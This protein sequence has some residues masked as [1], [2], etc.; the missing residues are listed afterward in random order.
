MSNA[1]K[2]RYDFAYFFEITD[3]NPNGDP[4]AGNLP[5]LDAETGQGLVTDV[6]LKRK[7]RNHVDL[8]K[9][10]ASSYRIFVREKAILN[11]QIEEAYEQ[12]DAVRAALAEWAAYQ[13]AKK[14]KKEKEGK[15]TERQAPAP[16]HF[17][18][19]A[20]MWMCE[21]FFDIRTFGAVMTTGKEKSDGETE[22][23][24]RRTAG[25]VR[26]P[27]QLGI[28]RSLHPIVS[29][30]HAL[31]V[32]AARTADKPIAEQVGIQGRKFTIPYALYR[33]HGFISP[34]LAGG[35][36]GT[37]F[38]EDDLALL[39]T[40]LN[41]MFENDKSAARANMRP[42]ACIAFRHESPL[43]NARADQLFARVVC[44]PAEGVQ[45]LPGEAPAN[46]TT[47]SLRPPRAF[48][49]YTLEVRGEKDMPSGVTV[50]R[51][52]DWR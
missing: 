3:G 49:D 12:S 45:P 13:K 26:G 34:S 7:V 40:A 29:Q 50:E 42:V 47:A 9:K 16:R 10:G 32:C 27:V 18:D 20:R 17:E 2:N 6:C 14:S 4:D 51:W 52:I 41:M 39:K 33:V 48:K 25:Q 43:G 1:I 24:I 23:K 8:E 21:Q 22:S 44:T 30:E 19:V 5:R 37:G 46:G 28:A 35:E 31:T 38:S 15:T 36:N 11:Q